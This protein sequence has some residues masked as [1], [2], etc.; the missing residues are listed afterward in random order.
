MRLEANISLAPVDQAK[1]PNYKVEIKNINSFK[2]AE[3]AISYE[4]KRQTKILDNGEIPIQET[5]G[6]NSNKN[7]T[8]PQRTKEDAEDYRYFPD[9]DLPPIRF[10]RENIEKIKSRIP[11]LPADKIKRW[12]N[13]YRIENR[14]SKQLITDIKTANWLEE[15]FKLALSKNAE[16]NKLAS[17]M[18]N[19]KVNVSHEIKPKKVLN[20][21]EKLNRS[22]DVSDEEIISAIK[23]IISK[24]EDA[25]TKFKNG[26]T[27]IVGFFIGQT[28]R[29]LGKKIDN[30]NLSKLLLNELKK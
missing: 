21:F 24:N 4:I 15:L 11:E 2:F 22:D 14:Y 30:K 25:V 17:A 18:V 28:M 9:P 19:K 5:R 26:E 20:M 6:W 12:N 16:P 29:K 27:K 23:K 13:V 3:Q 1:L 7:I 8:F 10:S